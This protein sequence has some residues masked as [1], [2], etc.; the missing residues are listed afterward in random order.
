MQS[1]GNSDLYTLKRQ[2]LFILPAVSD[3]NKCSHD[4]GT[5]AEGSSSIYELASY[6]NEIEKVN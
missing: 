4:I 1:K 3:N 5:D 6:H 2:N